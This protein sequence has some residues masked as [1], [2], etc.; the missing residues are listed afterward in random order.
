MEKPG[1]CPTCGSVLPVLDPRKVE[2]LKVWYAI[3]AALLDGPEPSETDAFLVTK[4]RQLRERIRKEFPDGDEPALL[5]P[6]N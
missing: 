3:F 6:R 1:K 2:A 4:M 5:A